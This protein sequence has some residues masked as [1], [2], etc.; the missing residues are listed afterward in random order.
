[1][2]LLPQRLFERLVGV[3]VTPELLRA[4]LGKLFEAMRDGGL[5]GVD[6]VPWFNGG[7][8]KTITVPPLQ[9]DDVAALKSA[10]ALNWSAIDP[11]IFGTLFERGLDP[12][13]RS[14][15]G[16]HYTDPATILRLVDPVVQRPLRAEWADTRARVAELIAKV[17]AL[18]A[19]AE[20]IPSTT[21]AL[22]DKYAR[23]RSR[24]NE[25]ERTAQGLFRSFLE[26]LRDYRVLDPAC[27]SG[28]FLYLALKG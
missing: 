15:L 5:F 26:R 20:T 7:L 13:K 16:A 25:A 24:A 21:K 10:S 3:Q 12:G 14:Q 8:F 19:E 18:R 2:G 1:V 23:L 22:R 28:N 4:Q 11:S 6:A 17:D 9:A 27:G